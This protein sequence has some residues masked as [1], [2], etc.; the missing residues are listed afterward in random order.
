MSD[1][2]G[3]DW[4][5]RVTKYWDDN[6]QEIVY[7]TIQR[8]EPIEL[9]EV[10]GY[11][12]WV[13]NAYDEED[14]EVDPRIDFHG[15]LKIQVDKSK[16][17]PAKGEG[18]GTKKG[19]KPE[20]SLA[21]IQDVDPAHIIGSFETCEIGSAF[22]GLSVHDDCIW[23]FDDK[24]LV[25]TE[26]YGDEHDFEGSEFFISVVDVVDDNG[27]PFILFTHVN[28]LEVAYVGKK[29]TSTRKSELEGL[30]AGERQKLGIFVP[31]D[32]IKQAALGLKLKA[33]HPSLE[34]GVKLED[35]RGKAE[36]TS[37]SATT[38]LKRKAEESPSTA[39]GPPCKK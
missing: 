12:A 20:G 17:E 15:C 33:S 36:E 14:I 26:D 27:H 24:N 10:L 21:N 8:E 19:S 38:P 23:T 7:T 32:D 29:Q 11:Y 34:T 16:T 13:F 18:K 28:D 1:Y 2:H 9:R 25:K 3:E 6:A 4:P 35:G 5:L 37:I 31:E 30:T 39:E 22:A